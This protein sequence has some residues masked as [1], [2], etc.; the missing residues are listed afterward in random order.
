MRS[1]KASGHRLL[2][3]EA[4]LETFPA[5]ASMVLIGCFAAFRSQRRFEVRV[6]IPKASEESSSSPV[7]FPGRVQFSDIVTQICAAADR[8]PQRRN[9]VGQTIAKPRKKLS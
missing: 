7:L 1:P 3:L 9:K 5:E 6:K 2:A 4:P 8:L